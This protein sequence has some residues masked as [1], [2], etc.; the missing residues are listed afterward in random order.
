VKN[1][2]DHPI[3]FTQYFID[4]EADTIDGLVQGNPAELQKW[5][6]QYMKD[7][8]GMLAH[9][10]IEAGGKIRP[11]AEELKTMGPVFQKRWEEFFAKSPDKP[12]LFLACSAG[13][14]GNPMGIPPRKYSTIAHA[15]WYS[16]AIGYLHITSADDVDSPLE[17]D[18]MTINSKEDLGAL[19]WGYKKGREIAR[20]MALHRGEFDGGHPTFPAGS[21]A[22][23]RPVGEPVDISAPP[24]QYTAEDDA[25]IDEWHQKCV[26]T[27]WHG[28]GT[29]AMKPRD[30][31]GVVDSK[32][33]VYGVKGLKV[34]DMSIAPSNVGA[35]T[36][37]TALTIGEK[38]ATII[39]AELGLTV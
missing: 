32:L 28:L 22:A 30:Q 2:Q 33:N 14:V 31:N 6:A 37:S 3:V 36:Y 7:A 12:V 29:C 27:M 4:D 15:C 20:R 39:G 35:N 5:G 9:N 25:A 26:S 1:Y 11:T 38:A 21:A 17:F 16:S 34:V 24:I 23:V 19:R 13:F 18:P 8:T 10:A